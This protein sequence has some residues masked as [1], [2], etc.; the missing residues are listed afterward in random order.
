MSFLERQ[1]V[2]F[3]SNLASAASKISADTT[4]KKS[5]ASPSPS[6]SVASTSSAVAPTA[7]TTPKKNKLEA[8][9]IYSQPE[10]TGH[11]A[12]I[13]TQM[14]FVVGTLK[15]KDKVMTLDEV[16]DHML[17]RPKTEADVKLRVDR[18]R[19]NPR[20]R[21]IPDPN[22]SEQTWQSGTYVHNPIIPG[23]R[24]R[25]SL[26]KYLQ[27]RKDFMGVVV[28]DL[29]DGWKKEEAHKAML[30]L[31]REHKILLVKTKKENNPRFVWGDDPTLWHDVDPE[32]QGLW[33]KVAVPSLD[34]INARLIA[35]GQK[36]TSEDPRAKLMKSAK[37]VE[38]KKRVNK[39]P[40]RL[41]NDHLSDVVEKMNPSKKK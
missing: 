3:S 10:L 18:L 15:E 20:I 4:T 19:D 33:H 8:G 9:A 11:G 23:V 7:G 39:R 12:E 32:F 38:K 34:D 6:P 27:D 13:A 31:E 29:E 21:W 24:T 28:R 1:R 35:A 14:V 41:T 30:A 36:P 2:G 22:L 5:V 26:L 40:V 16:L 17:P 37:K 25:Q